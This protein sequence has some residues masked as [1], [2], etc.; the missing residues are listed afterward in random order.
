MTQNHLHKPYQYETSK[1]QTQN[2][3]HWFNQLE[4]TLEQTLNLLQKPSCLRKLTLNTFR[5]NL[6]ILNVYAAISM[7]PYIAFTVSILAY[8]QDIPGQVHWDAV[9]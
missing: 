5:K 9:K 7:H 2:L 3:L 1:S 8:F 6:I 4:I